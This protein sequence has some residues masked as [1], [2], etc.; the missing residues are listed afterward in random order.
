MFSIR[1]SD[2][3][4]CFRCNMAQ[5]MTH[6]VACFEFFEYV[7]NERQRAA[8]LKNSDIWSNDYSRCCANKKRP[9][10]D[11]Q[12]GMQG[13]GQ[14][15]EMKKIKRKKL[16]TDPDFNP[17]LELNVR[18]ASP[19]QKSIESPTISYAVP[20]QNQTNTNSGVLNP[21]SINVLPR[22]VNRQKDNDIEFVR[23]IPP[24][25]I[26]VN[27]SLG[28]VNNVKVVNNRSANQVG[29]QRPL[30]Y[31]TSKIFYFLIFFFFLNFGT[32]S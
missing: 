15:P 19:I 23:S 25:R 13:L 10:E 1:D 27:P 5:I 18:N 29:N 2:S 32:R 9:A 17:L 14:G 22:I 11:D 12:L 28:S 6:R 20:L 7:H 30:Y 24:P 8:T 4:D 31:R 3:W 21:P 16:S 26:Q